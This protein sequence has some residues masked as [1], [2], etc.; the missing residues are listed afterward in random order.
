M[1]HFYSSKEFE[2]VFELLV[3][4]TLTLNNSTN[5][6][7][8]SVRLLVTKCLKKQLKMDFLLSWLWWGRVG[9]LNKPRIKKK[10]PL[11]ML[12]HKHKCKVCL[13]GNNLKEKGVAR[14]FRT[15]LYS[16]NIYNVI[17]HI[18]RVLWRVFDHWVHWNIYSNN[19]TLSWAIILQF[20]ISKKSFMIVIDSWS[21]PMKLLNNDLSKRRAAVQR[22]SL[23]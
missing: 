12:R 2:S 13:A 16:C 8:W 18:I 1:F 9:R 15:A 20:L 21:S 17:I 4:M 23:L 14:D 22:K 19:T 7:E 3:Q 6:N 5:G 11:K 10:N